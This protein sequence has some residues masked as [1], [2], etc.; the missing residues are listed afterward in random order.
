MYDRWWMFVV[1][2]GENTEIFGIGV[3]IENLFFQSRVIIA[4]F[5]IYT[6]AVDMV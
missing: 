6:C 1:L 3:I 2:Y 4:Y 5:G